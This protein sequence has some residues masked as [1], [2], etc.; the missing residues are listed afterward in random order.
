[1]SSKEPLLVV[2]EG[3]PQHLAWRYGWWGLFVVLAL[4]VPY[5]LGSFR[6]GQFTTSMIYMVGILGLNLIVGNMRLLA[7]AQSAFIGIGAFITLVLVQ[8]YDWAHW[9]TIPVV[10]V[11]TFGCGLLLGVPALRIKGLYLALITIAFAVTFPTLLKINKWGIA[12][13]TGGANGRT[14]SKSVEPPEWVQDLPG[15]GIS[16]PRSYIYVYFVALLITVGC[17][18]FV[19]N[20][21]Q[22]RPG[23]GI[24]AIRDNETG[25]AVSGVNITMYKVI[26]FGISAMLGGMAGVL[27]IM[28]FDFAGEASFSFLLVVTLL[29]GLVI[30]GVGTMA[31]PVI[32]GLVVVFVDHW[33]K[34]DAPTIDLGFFTI[35]E[36]GPL[37]QALFGVVLIVVTFFAPG[38]VA[39]LIAK[40]KARIIRV[41]PTPPVPATEHR[42]EPSV[43]DD[44]DVSPSEEPEPAGR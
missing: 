36:G 44:A 2:Q 3:S 33:A 31:G 10:L 22:S 6:V 38:G 34:N 28:R 1:M 15:V 7:L 16:L 21:M 8:D 12:D 4:V 24:I 43:G 32:G 20:L 17:F 9:M 18:L 27:W 25:A 30:G 14:V 19:R 13:K 39:S 5:H 35:G 40:I 37:G 26:T 11:V 41:I 29:V 42:D 23:R